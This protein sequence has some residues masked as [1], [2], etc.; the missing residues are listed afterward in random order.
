[1]LQA[2]GIDKSFF[3]NKVLDDVS[4]DV[5]AGEVHALIG[6]NGAGKSTLVNILSGNLA[7]D[8]G[9]VIFD[10]NSVSFS[11]PLEA[12]HA[13]ISVV[14]QELS[15]VP[16]ASVAENIFLRREITNALGLNNWNAMYAECE[17]VFG[18]MGVDINPRALA[19]SLS[20][21]MQQLVE[22]AKAV[23]LKA[24]LIF[25]DEPTSSLSEKEIAE[26]FKVVRDLKASG[27][28]IVFISHKLSELFEI[29]DRITVLRDGKYV[30]T[31][32]TAGLTSNEVISMMV[33][34]ALTSLYPE[35]GDS[36]GEVFFKCKNLSLFGAIQNVAFNLRRG[37]ILGFAGLIGAGR[38]EAMRAL[39]NAE[40]RLSGEFELEG[41]PLTLASP[42]DAMKKGIVYLSEDRKGS[43]LFLDYDMVHNIS[44]C[45]LERGSSFGMEN[46]DVM[47]HAAWDYIEQMDIRPKRP[48]AMV[49]SLSGGNQQKVLLAK[50]LNAQ[51]K[52]LIVDEPTRGVDVG[53]KALIHSKL[54]ELANSGCG[55]ILISSELPEVLGMSD[56]VVVF[57]GGT[58]AAELN[59]RDGCLSQEDVMNAAVE[60]KGRA[61]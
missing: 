3:G 58:V 50:S 28:G 55:V 23:A 1:M 43:G 61:S 16:N 34:R 38:T 53:A 20:V 4:F 59:N 52:I 25:M 60:W 32:D 37:E 54:R 29:S 57:R 17:R 51:P 26:L 21:G 24:K 5:R 44:S 12:M 36:D 47:L 31:R 45:V 22:V 9:D 13:G 19:G 33:G 15:I 46:R 48:S 40:P 6:E 30:G 35:R 18:Q 27:L 8:V 2:K 39:I 56:R 42:H 10:G 7:R 49:V 11:H 14:H 41:E